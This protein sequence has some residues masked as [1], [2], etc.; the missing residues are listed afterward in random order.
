MIYTEKYHTKEKIS[1]F[2]KMELVNLTFIEPVEFEKRFEMH[3]KEIIRRKKPMLTKEYVDLDYSEEVIFLKYKIFLADVDDAYVRYNKAFQRAEKY[4][5]ENEIPA[6]SK[7]FRRLKHEFHNSLYRLEYN[8]YKSW[9]DFVWCCQESLALYNSLR[10]YLTAYYINTYEVEKDIRLP[11]DG[12]YMPFSAETMDKI[13][14][15]GNLLRSMRMYS[16]YCPNVSYLFKDG[17]VNRRQYMD[18]YVKT[19]NQ[20]KLE[21]D[22]QKFKAELEKLDRL[23]G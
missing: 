11:R 2:N 14:R 4:I 9:K 23:R 15:Y 1:S 6:Y 22:E 3:M 10:K 5:P 12:V 8:A 20:V 7:G 19:M 17:R 13:A 21:F 18:Q 16:A